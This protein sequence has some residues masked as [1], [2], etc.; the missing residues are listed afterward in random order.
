M[1]PCTNI[2]SVMNIDDVAGPRLDL[3]LG[4]LLLQLVAAVS[5]SHITQSARDELMNIHTLPLI[6][7]LHVPRHD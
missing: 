5:Q 2:H 6:D 3:C 1:L 4:T 7:N